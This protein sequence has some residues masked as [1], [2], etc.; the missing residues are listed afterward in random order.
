MFC[1]TC[2]SEYRPGFSRCAT[3]DV[4]L[5]E[6]LH[7]EDERRH[8]TGEAPAVAPGAMLDYCGFLSL[9]EAREARDRLWRGGV[10]GEIVIREPT[11]AA[12]TDPV[13]EEYWLR[14]AAADQRTVIGILGYDLA[15]PA[16]EEAAS[17]LTCSDCGHHVGTEETFCAHCGARFE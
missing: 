1:P 7:S 16:G 4:D 6:E 12:P 5:V 9:D 2:R 14:V 3:C 13:R 8:S 17:G 10:R 15:E 11:G